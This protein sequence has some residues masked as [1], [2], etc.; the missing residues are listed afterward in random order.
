MPFSFSRRTVARAFCFA[1]FASLMS[2]ARAAV[3]ITINFTGFSTSQRAIFSQAETYWETQL[4]GYLP[5]ISLTGFTID[6]SAPAIDGAGGILGQA[7][8]TTGV[9]QGGYVLTTAGEMEFD[10]ADADRLESQGLFS[11]VVLHEM[12]HVIGFGTWWNANGVYVDGTG[13]YLGANGLNAYRQEF[14]S[15]ANFVPV[16]ITSGPGTRDGHWAE[17]TTVFD[18]QGRPLRNELMTGF[19]NTPTYISNTTLASFRDL[20]YV[21]AVVSAPEPGTFALLA[22]GTLGF[23]MRRRK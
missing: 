3:D 9:F 1:A 23:F 17:L 6:A 13:Q 10:S 18:P 2:G 8:P 12:A 7:G 21:T 5:G 16:D 14:D 11:D 19:L 4:V 22:V 20:G 15:S